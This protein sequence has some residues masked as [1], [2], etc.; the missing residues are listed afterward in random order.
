MVSVF[1]KEDTNTLYVSKANLRKSCSERGLALKGFKK[2]EFAIYFT[3]TKQYLKP[4]IY[5]YYF[6][7]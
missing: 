4:S 5:C 7:T 1:L 6:E 3:V 2:A